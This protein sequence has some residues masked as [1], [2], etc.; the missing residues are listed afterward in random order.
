MI[1]L[2][3]LIG[4]CDLTPEEV[5]VV[6]EHEHVS[7]AMAAV[8][9]NCLLQSQHGC[10]RIRDMLTDEIRTAVRRHDVPRAR[11]LVSTLR[12][13]LHEHPNA[14]IRHAA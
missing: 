1:S 7:Q 5:Q 14:A 11:Q 6:A 12:H 3:D 9:G 10:G 8:L 4:F 13:F 2:E